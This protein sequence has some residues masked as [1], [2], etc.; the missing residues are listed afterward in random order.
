MQLLF[1]NFLK[2]IPDFVYYII[3][4]VLAIVVMLVIVLAAKKSDK[5]EECDHDHCDCHNHSENETSEDVK[6]TKQEV[7]TEEKTEEI[8]KAEEKTTSEKTS[9]NTKTAQA[10]TSTAKTTKTVKTEKKTEPEAKPADE[11]QEISK[12][13]KLNRYRVTYDKEQQNWVVK[14]DGATRASKRCATKEEALKVAK[15][16]AKKKDSHLSVHKKDGKFQKKANI[17]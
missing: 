12:K 17:K 14:M 3:A 10:K 2:N 16:L 4:A 5:H 15:E 6:E 11:E 7:K 1:I 8:K 13:D 9:K